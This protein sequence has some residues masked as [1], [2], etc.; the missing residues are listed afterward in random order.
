MIDNALHFEENPIRFEARVPVVLNQIHL[1]FFPFGKMKCHI[2]LLKSSPPQT[3]FASSSS[4]FIF[5]F[6]CRYLFQQNILCVGRRHAF[7][8][9]KYPSRSPL[10][11]PPSTASGNVSSS[12]LS[13]L[14]PAHKLS[15]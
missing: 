12:E 1:N 2:F 8:Q 11:R 7:W 13:Q 14:I 9:K 6:F 5:S 3:I 4:Q 15:K 10:I